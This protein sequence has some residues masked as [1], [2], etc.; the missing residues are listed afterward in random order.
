MDEEE[1]PSHDSVWMALEVLNLG[2]TTLI[3]DPMKEEPCSRKNHENH[4]ASSESEQT[5]VSFFFFSPLQFK[6]KLN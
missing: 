2:T 1:G 6:S 5:H 3:H 4:S